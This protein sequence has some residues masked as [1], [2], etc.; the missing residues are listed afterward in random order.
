MKKTFF[1]F[2]FLLA[3]L[4]YSIEMTGPYYKIVNEGDTINLGTIGPGQTVYIDINPQIS[5][6]G[7]HGIG[8]FYD[9]AEASNQPE[10]WK[11]KK[12]KLY[13]NPLHVEI[14]APPNAKAGEYLN[15]ISV[16]DE[17]NKEGLGEIIFY[18]SVKISTEVMDMSVNPKN[19]EVGPGQPARF[20]IT[21]DN[22]GGASDVF[23]VQ[24]ENLRQW[25]F[26][27]YVYVPSKSSK[28]IVYEI[29]EN[30]EE[31]YNPVI[32][33]VSTSSDLISKQDE[34]QI[35]V[36]SNLL[37]DYKATNHGT[38]IFPIL[39]GPIYSFAGLISNLW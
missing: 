31:V 20:T 37:N 5:E 21:I 24:G 2:L 22:T 10:G 17:D 35:A 6:G 34:V 12:S 39:E 32:T 4:V 14:T 7:I 1:I 33:V 11:Q 29:V 13:G 3:G 23:E 16:I 19:V 9:T 8:G 18:V 36:R 15:T 38:M 26:K 25:N 30:E 27:K 28:T